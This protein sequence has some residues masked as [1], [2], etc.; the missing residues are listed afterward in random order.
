MT[1]MPL[2]RR[3]FGRCRARRSRPVR[4]SGGRVRQ[5]RAEPDSLHY[6]RTDPFQAP[7]PGSCGTKSPSLAAAEIEARASERALPAFLSMDL[8]I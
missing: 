4:R 2:R 6:H 8:V 5:E 7:G 1:G 3:L